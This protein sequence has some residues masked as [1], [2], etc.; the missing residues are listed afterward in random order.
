MGVEILIVFMLGFHPLP[1]PLQWGGEGMISL[2]YNLA[3]MT[4]GA[5]KSNRTHDIAK[6]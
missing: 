6:D 1:L 2:C 3:L 4:N 5:I